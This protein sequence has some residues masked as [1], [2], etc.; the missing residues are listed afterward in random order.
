MPAARNTQAAD[1][2]KGCNSLRCSECGQINFY[3]LLLFAFVDSEMGVLSGLPRDYLLLLQMFELFCLFCSF[4]TSLSR[5][6]HLLCL[7]GFLCQSAAI[8][9]PSSGIPHRCW[10]VDGIFSC[11]LF[12]LTKSEARLIQLC[13]LLDQNGPLSFYNKL[14]KFL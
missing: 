4:L 1:E 12:S 10:S 14:L 2:G 11:T 7:F 8:Y 5:R 3:G 6:S 9:S 13:W